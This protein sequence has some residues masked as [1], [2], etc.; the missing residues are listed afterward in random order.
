MNE[1]LHYIRQALVNRLTN[2]V[3]FGGSYVPVYNRVPATAS[4]PYIKIYSL[5]SREIDQNNSNF[6]TLC[7]TRIEV[8]TAFDG[9]DG[10]EYQSNNITDQIVNLVRTR[11]NGYY[12]LSSANFSVYTCE[13]ESIKYQ[14]K[15][16]EDKTYFRAFITISNRI[17]KV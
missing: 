10:G 15:E 7:E 14:E 12:D 17:E 13:I 16:Q 4:E 9:D 5:Q 2:A 6:T 8:V 1:A 3:S 11:S